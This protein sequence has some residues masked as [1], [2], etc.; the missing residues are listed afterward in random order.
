MQRLTRKIVIVNNFNKTLWTWIYNDCAIM[1]NK[2][3]L[4]RKWAHGTQIRQKRLHIKK[5][6]RKNMDD[7]YSFSIAIRL[8]IFL[9]IGKLIKFHQNVCCFFKIWFWTGQYDPF[10]TIIDKFY[11]I[12]KEFCCLWVL[13]LRIW[14]VLKM[15]VSKKN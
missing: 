9:N 6:D 1:A 10:Y 14:N 11:L 2:D 5:K 3:F 8:I 15:H 4:W 7:S 12:F 13:S